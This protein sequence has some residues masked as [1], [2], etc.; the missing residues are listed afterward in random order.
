MTINF[1]KR[2]V[3]ARITW[4]AV[5]GFLLTLFLYY[6]GNIRDNDS[7][8]QFQQ[9]LTFHFNDWHPVVMALAWSALNRAS[10]GPQLMLVLQLALYWAS[11]YFLLAAA[12]PHL[13]SR[14][15]V[16]MVGLVAAPFVLVFL[17]E[18]VKDV[19]LVGAWAFAATCAYWVR[20]SGKRLP[21]AATIGL[22]VLVLYGGLLRNNAA[23]VSAP[24]ALYVVSDR[25]WLASAWKTVV[26]YVAIGVCVVIV[27]KGL[28]AA[29]NATPSMQL[30]SLLTFDLVGISKATRVNMLPLPLTA[31][32]FA[33]V[34]DSYDGS[35][36]DFI[37]S[38]PASF[39][40][41]REEAAGITNRMML[42]FWLS[43]VAAH[44]LAYVAHRAR[45]LRSFAFIRPNEPY[46]H[47]A[48]SIFTKPVVWIVLL[49]AVTVWFLLSELPGPAARF[50]QTELIVAVT[51]LATYVPFGVSWGFRYCYL[52]MTCITFTGCVLVSTGVPTE[53]PQPAALAGR[54]STQTD[55]VTVGPGLDDR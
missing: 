21:I 2:L 4:L 10:R 9:S 12:P 14:R 49:I 47:V 23:I 55:A 44:P 35:S 36:Q 28:S 11:A 7:V 3:T 17:G 6:P 53:A 38:G 32:E 52:I 33:R 46:S 16:A 1:G 45:F 29:V 48:R 39:I 26:T 31:P 24:L 15:R 13:S 30:R 19:Q 42:R 50:V 20:S 18:I 41:G 43:G 27:S 25:P 54:G 5:L 37:R 8:D 51:Y 34:L 22:A 40:W